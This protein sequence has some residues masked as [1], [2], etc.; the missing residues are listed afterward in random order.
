MLEFIKNIQTLSSPF[1]DTALTVFNF[2]SQQYFL[3]ILVASIYWTYDKKKGEALAFSII[4]TT[5]FSC[6]LKGVFKMP[7]PFTFD[8]VKALNKS[9]A[10]GYS[11]PS[12]DTAAA[13]ATAVTVSGWTK[14]TVLKILLA[15][16]V[17]IIGFARMYFG[18][19][20]PADVLGGLITG[21]VVAFGIKKIFS[22]FNAPVFTALIAT[23]ILIP[24][25]FFGQQPDYFKTFGLMLG[26]LCGVYTEHTF[27][28]FDYKISRGKKA[29]RFLIGIVGLI[30]I[31]VLTKKFFPQNNF[32]LVFEK[33]LLTFFAVGIYP[34]I[35]KKLKF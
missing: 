24:F 10:P 25:M 8:G 14:N 31:S 28:N 15:L 3:I 11:F 4:F 5:A 26:A 17:I 9:S 22:T 13:T 34:A 16:Y 23:I 19:H 1:L 30:L 12:A 6:G 20:F 27:V 2:L 32:F 7:R 21:C 35:F 29:A 18:L 33:F